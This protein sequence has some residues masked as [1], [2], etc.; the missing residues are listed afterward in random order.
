ME[1]QNSISSSLKKVEVQP[2]QEES[3]SDSQS[4]SF[5]SSSVSV[6][7]QLK[8]VVPLSA[9]VPIPRPL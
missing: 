6:K 5:D 1:E 3:S 9:M 7:E 8:P 2:I 4:F